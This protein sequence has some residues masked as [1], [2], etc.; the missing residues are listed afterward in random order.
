MKND[1]LSHLNITFVNDRLEYI[2][3]I[4]NIVDV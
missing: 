2:F 1:Y 3:Y 4:D